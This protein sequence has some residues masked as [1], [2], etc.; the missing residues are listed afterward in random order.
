MEKTVYIYKGTYGHYKRPVIYVERSYPQIVEYYER[1]N[2]STYSL[3]ELCSNLQ[4]HGYSII[5]D[6]PDF[7]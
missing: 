2:V 1:D 5:F 3:L 7:K 4:K 6:K